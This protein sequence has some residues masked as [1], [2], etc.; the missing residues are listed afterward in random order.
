MDRFFVV[1][2]EIKDPNLEMTG[3]ITAFLREH[4]REVIPVHS[5]EERIG[6]LSPLD[7]DRDCLL[8]LG[9][10]GTVL[11]AAAR[12]REIQIPI[13]G[14]NMGTLGYLAEIERRNWREALEKVLQGDYDIS[15]RM[16]LEGH[17]VF[18]D[19]RED[20]RREYALNDIVVSRSGSLRVLN[21]T[22]L[23]NGQMITRVSADGVIAATPTGSTA[24]NLSAG[25]P[26]IEPSSHMIVVTPICSHSMNARSIVLSS[27]DRITLRVE[28]AQ[29]S[30]D[31]E[32][33]ANFDGA[34]KMLLCQG[35]R[36]E[37]RR[38]SRETRLIRISRQ[39]FL[40]TLHKKMYQVEG[41]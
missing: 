24:Y 39:S 13:L 22:L 18:A 19:G 27:K 26:I 5:W 25:G 2:N 9:G 35:D 40:H 3:Q 33:E 6:G 16:M 10:D 29:H 8:V 32:A 4:G 7:P 36:I 37:I 30:S 15:T 23:V 21:I 20:P 11:D 1:T 31:I 12:L 17:K 41:L 14:I 38:A 28:Q 34:R